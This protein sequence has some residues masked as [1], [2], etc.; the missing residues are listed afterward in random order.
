MQ[1]AQQDTNDDWLQCD[2][3]RKWRLLRCP[4]QDRSSHLSAE[5][6]YC[7]MN[8]DASHAT[9]EAPQRRPR[10]MKRGYRLAPVYAVHRLTDVRTVVRRQDSSLVLARK[11]HGD[12][13][14]KCFRQFFVHWK[15]YDVSESTWEDEDNILMGLSSTPLTRGMAAVLTASIIAGS[16]SPRGGG[17]G[18]RGNQRTDPQ[19]H[20]ASA[21]PSANLRGEGSRPAGSDA[22]PRRAH[23]RKG[24]AHPVDP[25]RRCTK[26][27]VLRCAG[28]C[29]PSC[30]RSR[31]GTAN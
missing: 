17:L 19:G 3:C 24:R 25:M 2:R 13:T 6:W 21:R 23:R 22:A 16:R 28:R 27:R 9:C 20:P 5:R 30:V 15:G 29:R 12:S 8:P 11:D 18:G 14:S 4:P 10:P 7:E 1:E 31:A 26:W